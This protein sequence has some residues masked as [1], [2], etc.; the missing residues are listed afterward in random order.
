M[1][2]FVNRLDDTLISGALWKKKQE[3]DSAELPRE[4][5]NTKELESDWSYFQNHSWSKFLL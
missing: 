4:N 3:S 1:S 5:G 2:S